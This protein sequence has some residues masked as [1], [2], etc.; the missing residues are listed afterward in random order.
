MMSMEIDTAYILFCFFLLGWV[1]ADIGRGVY[2]LVR[3]FVESRTIPLTERIP[4]SLYLIERAEGYG[5]MG[6]Q[7]RRVQS[8]MEVVGGVIYFPI[9]TTHSVPHVRKTAQSVLISRGFASPIIGKV[10]L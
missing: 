10:E 5:V 2:R 4:P 8:T 1:S 6:F 7:V 9:T 3:N